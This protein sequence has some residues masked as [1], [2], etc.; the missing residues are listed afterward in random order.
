NYKRVIQDPTDVDARGAMMIGAHFGGLAVENSMLGAAHACAMPLT[1]RYS[2]PHGVAIALLLPHV[3]KW[4]CTE[5]R[6]QY[7]DLS[8]GDLSRRLRELAGIAELPGALHEAS[9]PEEALPRLA[10]EAATQWTGRF[11]P[12]PFDAAAALEIYQWAY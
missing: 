4:N 3:V 11:N 1:A 2:I 12:R 7:E 6:Y 5:A 9:V 8:A 10:E